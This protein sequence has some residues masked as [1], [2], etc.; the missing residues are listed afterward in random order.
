MSAQ[1]SP[2]LLG[3]YTEYA[4]EFDVEKYLTQLPVSLAFL[5]EIS[6][7]QAHGP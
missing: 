6:Q 3:I 5:V 4:D 1:T 7:A 2:D